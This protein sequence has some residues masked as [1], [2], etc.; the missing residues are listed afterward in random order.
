ML[1]SAGIQWKATLTSLLVAMVLVFAGCKSAAQTSLSA[2]E[3][4]NR[5][6]A[7]TST[8]GT[9]TM[10]TV[11]TGLMEMTSAEKGQSENVK[12]KTTGTLKLEFD[13]TKKAA[14]LIMQT[15][16]EAQSPPNQSFEQK[17]ETYFLDGTLYMGT[18]DTTGKTKWTK[19]KFPSADGSFP[20]A[21]TINDIIELVRGSQIED[22]STDKFA[23]KNAYVLKVRPDMAKLLDLM[24]RG[25]NALDNSPVVANS[26]GNI[27]KSFSVKVWVSM[28][29]FRLLKEEAQI[30]LGM[31]ANTMGLPGSSSLSLDMNTNTL[32]SY[33][34]R[35]L[36]T[37][38]EEALN[39]P[40]T[41]PS[42]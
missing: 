37:V 6:I 32:F 23:G 22:L 10:D 40:Q 21:T 2:Q 26:I 13:K 24:I 1:T 28:D 29:D 15:K 9:Y 4:V 20:N 33:D 36:I 42:K 38:P 3:V 30:T 34:T 27:V 41:L 35:V 11:M 8:L 39:A 17:M 5:A 18:T 25:N 12:V 16:A 7:A 19:T 14:K 31:D